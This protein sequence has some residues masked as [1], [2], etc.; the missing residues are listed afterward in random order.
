MLTAGASLMTP[1]KPMLAEACRSFA[2]A[3]KRCPAGFWA[4][5]KYDGERLQ[6]HFDGKTFRFFSRNLKPVAPHK[7]EHIEKYVP[8]ACQPVKIKIKE[9]NLI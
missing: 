4:E 2:K 7:V 1:V 8:K 6:I 9:I 5:I 3:F